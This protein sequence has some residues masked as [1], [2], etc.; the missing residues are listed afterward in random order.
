MR[1]ALALS[2]TASLFVQT[3]LAQSPEQEFVEMLGLDRLKLRYRFAGRDS[4]LADVAGTAARQG[5]WPDMRTALALLLTASLIA[6]TELAQFSEQEFFD[7]LGLD[8]LKLT[9][10]NAGP[11]SGLADVAGTA[12][13]QGFLPDAR[14]ALTLLLTAS[15]IAQAGLAQSSVRDLFEILGLDHLKLTDRY[16]G[17]EL[18]ADVARTV[19]SG[20]CA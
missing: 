13:R 5:F 3:T 10:R 1:T 11:D 12:A 18:L 6:Q 19:A 14:T 4:G 7:M 20:V 2:L 15:L 16:A 17:R 9:Y 8:Y